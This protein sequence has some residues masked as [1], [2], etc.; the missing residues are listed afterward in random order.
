LFDLL[1]NEEISFFANTTISYCVIGR[2]LWT[3]ITNS[4]DLYEAPLAKAA[5]PEPILIEPANWRHEDGATLVS[6]VVDLIAI[7]LAAVSVDKVVPKKANTCLLG[8]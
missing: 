1:T 5:A 8:G 6:S 7:A 3:G 2:V 4:V